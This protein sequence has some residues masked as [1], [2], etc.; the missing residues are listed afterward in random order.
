M[1]S[2]L[3]AV[4]PKI[5]IP[6]PSPLFAKYLRSSPLIEP[7]KCDANNVIGAITNLLDT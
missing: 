2:G 4:E 1:P 3:I 6:I 7:S 5:Y